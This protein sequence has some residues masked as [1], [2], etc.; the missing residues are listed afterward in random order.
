MARRNSPRK[1]SAPGW[2]WMTFGLG[3][4][5]IVAIGVYLRTPS[6]AT[7]PVEA[8]ASIAAVQPSATRSST[9]AAAPTTQ[10]PTE[11]A[12]AAQD[13]FS[14]YEVLPEFE[15]VVLDDE[16]PATATARRPP[17]ETPGSFLLQEGTFS[18]SADADRHKPSLA[19]L[20]FES[21]VQRVTIEDV[22]F[23]L[24]RIGPIGNLDAAKRTQRQLRDAGVDTLLMKVPN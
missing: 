23:N 4:G 9:R 7:A 14:F 18:A 10:T 1:E 15:V 12:S 17:A 22:V 6:E 13:R 19:Q 3:V 20:G 2:V 5:L 21:H 16:K 11:R 24:V 8:A